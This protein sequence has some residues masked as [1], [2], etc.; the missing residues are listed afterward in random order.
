MSLRLRR[1]N[2]ERL[3]RRDLLAN[4]EWT[5]IRPVNSGGTATEYE[6][7]TFQPAELQADSQ[8]TLTLEADQ[9]MVLVIQERLRSDLYR[10][11]RLDDGPVRV[12][13]PDGQVAVPWVSRSAQM[14]DTAWTIS[15]SEIVFH[16]PTAI[17]LQLNADW[18]SDVADMQSIRA[19]VGLT[20]IEMASD[21]ASPF[22]L[23]LEDAIPSDEQAFLASFSPAAQPPD[24]SERFESTVLGPS[25]VV[26]EGAFGGEVTVEP[27]RSGAVNGIGD[28]NGEGENLALHLR[29]WNRADERPQ[30]LD[31]LLLEYDSQTGEL[32]A[33]TNANMPFQA[34]EL[35]SRSSQLTGTR[36]DGPADILGSWFNLFRPEKYF[37]LDT[38]G[39]TEFA[40]GAALPAG[41][42]R[43]TLQQDIMVD[44]AYRVG[45]KWS[46]VVWSIDGDTP[47]EYAEAELFR[48]IYF[49][50]TTQAAYSWDIGD[51]TEGFID[52]DFQLRWG[53]N[54][55]DTFALPDTRI[56][57]SVF[58]GN[59]HPLAQANLVRCETE[60]CHARV[61]LPSVD[62]HAL[63]IRFINVST[64]AELVIDNIRWHEVTPGSNAHGYR[65]T[66]ADGDHLILVHESLA[67]RH[68]STV[69]D[70]Q[71]MLVTAGENLR[72]LLFSAGDGRDEHF[73][74]V[75]EPVSA[76]VHQWQGDTPLALADPYVLNLLSASPPVWGSLGFSVGSRQLVTWFPY[77]VDMR[78]C[79]LN[80]LQWD[81]P[82]FTELNWS[83]SDGGTRL[84]LTFDADELPQADYAFEVRPGS[85]LRTDGTSLSRQEF[86]V[87][88]LPAELLRI[89]LA[90]RGW[91]PPGDN[92]LVME[93]S[94]GVWSDGFELRLEKDGILWDSWLADIDTEGDI[95]TIWLGHLEPGRYRLTT[96]MMPLSVWDAGSNLTD[97]APFDIEFIVSDTAPD[98]FTSRFDVNQDGSLD[99]RDLRLL[100]AISNADD[101]LSWL[102]YDLDGDG[103]ATST[104][105]ALLATE[106]LGLRSGDVNLDGIFDDEDLAILAQTAERGGTVGWQEGDFTG[107]GQLTTDDLILAFQAGFGGSQRE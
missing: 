92:V 12:L 47:L 28:V 86:V 82:D 96:P 94:E 98:G 59:A 84:A 14:T 48:E 76:S 52:F 2:F 1:F 53:D 65:V 3:E 85:C 10:P 36:P 107:D 58:A 13:V 4:L 91:L 78:T 41:L 9:P 100:H 39:M 38:R 88:H 5:S 64:E 104:D 44:G 21:T 8:L 87:D 49:P 23:S 20:R 50:G 15:G 79:S 62:H 34:I 11:L 30:F 60:T 73:D 55:I 66:V 75:L 24:H 72:H 68:D 42:D 83:A 6:F 37:V 105:Y 101:D 18:L 7:R 93:F 63:T 77:I 26:R 57:V 81:G 67:A 71:G 102:P 97:L 33:R 106:G 45:S 32:T 74:L 35:R 51:A 19:F 16:E 61:Y 22:V 43:E 95:A 103:R 29:T 56:R 70:E 99:F 80:D 27:L 31:G 69:R 89:P 90:E 25:W 40:F 17:T 54:D 46:Q